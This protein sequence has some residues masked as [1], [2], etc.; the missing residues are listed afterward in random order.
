MAIVLAGAALAAAGSQGSFSVE[1]IPIYAVCIA[2]AFGIQWIGFVPAYRL[3]TEAFFDLTGSITYI[4]VLTVAVALVPIV[5]VRSWLLLVL[6]TIW[7]LR[8]GSFLFRR[9]RSAGSDRRFD[10]IKPSFAGFLTAWTLQG[11]WVSFSLAAALA[12]VTSVSRADTGGFAVIGTLTWAAGFTLEVIADRQKS[13]FVSDPANRGRFI[14]AGVWAWSRHPNYFGEI[15]LWIGIALIAVPN[16]SGWQWITL[17]SPVFV[18]VLLTRI[19]G[20]PLLE[21]QAEQKW[22][23]QDDYEAYKRATPVLIPRRPR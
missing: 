21:R 2:L 5:D 7:A 4:S 6:V 23:G 8:L 11:L 3:Q 13:R 9:I 20:I 19:S 16:L 22:G 1:G 10:D 14:D 18:I 17:T 12:A 15:V